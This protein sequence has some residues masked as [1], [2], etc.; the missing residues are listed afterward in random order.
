MV[1]LLI[2]IQFLGGYNI[3]I[4]DNDLLIILGIFVS[5]MIVHILITDIDIYFATFT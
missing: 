5:K 1:L 2:P 3:I 4:L